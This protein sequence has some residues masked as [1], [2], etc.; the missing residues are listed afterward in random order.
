VCRGA[1]VLVRKEE[2]GIGDPARVGQRFRRDT[3]AGGPVERLDA[4]V[5][6]EQRDLDAVGAQLE[7]GRVG[8][9][10]H[11][12]RSRRPQATAW[13]RAPRYLCSRT[14]QLQATRRPCQALGGVRLDAAVAEAFLDAA[15][16][17]A[18]QA[19][20][21]AIGQLRAE[22]DERVRQQCL[23]V[24]RADYEA[25]RA[26]RQFDACEPENRLVARTLERA[27]EVALSEAE[28]ARRRLVDVE[29]QRP[30]A[31]TDGEVRALKRAAADVRRVW[32]ARTTTD[33]DR[34]QL[35]RTLVTDAVLTVDRE[36]DRAEVELF[37]QG[38]A[39]TRLMVQLNRPPAKRTDA[40]KDLV[41]LIAR[42][43]EHSNDR[44]IAMVLSKQGLMTATDLPFTESRVAGVRE[45]AGI[46]AARVRAG[47]DGISIRAAAVELG[48]STQTIR[49]WVREGLLPAAQTAPHGPWRIC[50]T[51]DARAKFKPDVPDGYLSL[52]MAARTLGLARQTVLNQVRAGQRDA[53]QVVNGKRRGLRIHVADTDALC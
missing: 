7:R 42:L 12:E 5:D 30:A 35:L 9:R 40:P 52:E 38:G 41:E 11:A 3:G 48:V 29:R 36:N 37:W 51:D 44:E 10:S 28:R 32:A 8:D 46:P 16:P 22:H 31:L 21:D 39:Q 4:R 17:A 45:R 47:G 15:T 25:D 24:E 49:R 20:A 19:T 14:H 2:H 53:I 50:L 26:R 6:D 34:K 13:H 18:V 43:A 23:A 1:R 27:L 33:R